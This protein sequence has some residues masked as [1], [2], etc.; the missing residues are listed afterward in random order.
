MIPDHSG[1]PMSAYRPT[2]ARQNEMPLLR[3]RWLGRLPYTEAWDLQR[4]IHE[5]KVVGRTRDDYL[6]LLEHPPVFTIGRNGDGSNLLVDRVGLGVDVHHVDRGGDITFHGP[7]QLV[8]YPILTLDDPKQIVPYVRRL[9]ETLIETLSDFGVEAWAEPGYTGVWTE[10]GKVAAIGVRVARRVTMHGFALNLHPDLSYFGMMNPCGIA[11]R[12]V[13]TL[14]ELVGRKVTL[15]EATEVLLPRFERVF[16]YEE[17]ETQ[18]GAFARGQGRRSEFEVDRLVEAGT[19]S[20]EKRTCRADPHQ[21][22]S[23][24]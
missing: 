13:T 18:L 4:A 22:A 15:E 14:S 2:S 20:H 7:G 10:R 23:S 1:A 11:D 8:G 12:P 24:R 6:L 3:T 9:E 5:G 16:G 17:S 19:F 21:R